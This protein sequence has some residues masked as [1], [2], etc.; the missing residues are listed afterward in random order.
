MQDL[1][2]DEI[3]AQNTVVLNLKGRAMKPA[4]KLFLSAFL[5]PAALGLAGAGVAGPDV[6]CSGCHDVAPVPEDHMEVDEVSVESCTMCHEASGE[7]PFFRTIHAK[8]GEALGCD[9]CHSDASPESAAR[10]K[11]MLGE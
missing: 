4:Q 3:A 8:H 6:D 2:R 11:E 7:D 1:P 9:S 5:L 10:L